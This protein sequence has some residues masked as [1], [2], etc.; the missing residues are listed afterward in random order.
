MYWRMVMVDVQEDVMVD[1]QED[2]MVDVQ[3]DG[4]G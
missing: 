4:D 3:E 1:V 2:V